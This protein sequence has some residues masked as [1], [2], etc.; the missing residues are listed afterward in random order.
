MSVPYRMTASDGLGYPAAEPGRDFVGISGTLELEPGQMRVD[1]RVPMIDDDESE[2]PELMR[3]Q[4]DQPVGPRHVDYG[5][6]DGRDPEF[7]VPEVTVG[8]GD[9]ATIM[10]R[11]A[12]G[13]TM[14][15][16]TVDVVAAGSAT[17]GA[18]TGAVPRQ[19]TFEPGQRTATLTVPTVADGIADPGESL[20][21]R[22]SAPG[23]TRFANANRAMRVLIQEPPALAPPVVTP[24]RDRTA[25]KVRLLTRRA[26]L[27]SRLRLRVRCSEA[28]RS[29][30]QL[31]LPRT[32]ARRLGLPA[33]LARGT[34]S[35][36]RAGTATATLRVS[37][38]TLARLRRVLPE[39][40][41]LRLV[42]RDAAGNARTARRTLTMRR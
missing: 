7:T 23:I 33:V 3:L 21:L 34:A 10:V 2:G 40:L 11:R 9:T 12:P 20:E 39:R 15:G 36:R 14:L 1:L 22:L 38:R 30:V 4:L 35:T 41:E 25:P 24:S 37:R 13:L 32:R 42:V 17:P 29:T 19:V 8:E 16:T 18:D 28:C 27:R 5:I 6:D 31:R 26:R